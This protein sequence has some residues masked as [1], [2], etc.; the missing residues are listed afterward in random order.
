MR[1]VTG[2]E[3]AEMTSGEKTK[4]FVE[5]HKMSGVERD[6]KNDIKNVC[7]MERKEKNVVG[8]VWREDMYGGWEAIVWIKSLRKLYLVAQPH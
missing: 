8:N 2:L 7:K 1:G 4:K 6:K 5:M 3:R